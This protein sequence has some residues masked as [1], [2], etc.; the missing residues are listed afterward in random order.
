MKKQQ[1][2]RFEQICIWTRNC[3]NNHEITISRA[4]EDASFRR[5]FRVLDSDLSYI[6]MDAPPEHEAVSPFISI[7]EVLEK[8]GVN[9]PHIYASDIEQGFLLL[10][11][12]GQT[13]LLSSLNN[14]NVEQY[15][16]QAID[17]LVEL[18]LTAAEPTLFPLYDVEK[19]NQEMQLFPD[20]FLSRHLGLD[21]P[22]CLPNIFE[23]L[24]NNAQIQPQVLVHRDYHSRNLMVT[25]TQQLG[26]IDFQDAVIGPITYDLVSLLRDCYISW[27]EAI[28]DSCLHYYLT[29]AKS[30]GLEINASFN[31][32]KQ[33]FDLM[34]LQRHLKVLGIFCRLNYRDGKAHY[35]NDLPQT[36]RYVLDI[37]SR[38]D[39]YQSLH[40][41][42]TSQPRIMAML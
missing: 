41:F 3:L 35:L 29:T 24:A 9:V 33:W 30:K 37:S 26:V 18:Q 15:Y 11:D 5:Y 34:G 38:Y 40:R 36:L 31:T 16:H 6:L 4:S 32:F 19:L 20:W 25:P 39:E 17:E 7:A 8:Q 13:A 2:S 42:L 21:I 28:I 22:D 1:D 14:S 12:F 23:Q 27:P 10:T